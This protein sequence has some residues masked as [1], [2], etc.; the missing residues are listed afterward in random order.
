MGKLP[1]SGLAGWA[2]LSEHKQKES[3]GGCGCDMCS[4]RTPETST[5]GLITSL[6]PL[7][8]CFLSS[9]P[10]VPA[11][12]REA[13]LVSSA[14]PLWEASSANYSSNSWTS[15]LMDQRAT[16][17]ETL[18]SQ[19][20]RKGH[21]I[22]HP[23]LSKDLHLSG[24]RARKVATGQEAQ[25]FTCDFYLGNSMRLVKAMFGRRQ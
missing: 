13:G 15:D 17:S 14:L 9:T 21:S 2:N 8:A 19:D 4:D 18:R 23:H 25:T 11:L 5:M 24:L 16:A 22:K 6:P 1:G 3:R 10:D 7:S 20:L 12:M